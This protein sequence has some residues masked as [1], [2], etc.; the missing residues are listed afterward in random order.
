MHVLL[1]L[2][3]VA[4]AVLAASVTLNILRRVAGWEQRRDL[5]LLVLAAPV[6]GLGLSVAGLH[7]F[8][9]RVCFLSAPPW[10]RTLGA[11]FPLAMA[12]IALGGLGLGLLRL[13]LMS[14]TITRRSVPA[15]PDLQGLTESLARGLQIRVPRVLLCDYDRPL[16]LSCGLFRPTIL[17]SSW[18]IERL[19]Q[20]ELESV[21]A[22]ELGHV[23]RRDYPV[24]WL[25][26]VLRD[27]FFYLPPTWVAYR[28]LKR[29]GELACDD[30]AVHATRRPL[31]L[32]SALG[33]VWKQTLTWP[34]LSVA[35]SLAASSHA[36]ETRIGRLLTAP[37]TGPRRPRAFAAAF[38]SGAAILVGLLAAEALNAMI[39]FTPMGCGP[40]GVWGRL[41]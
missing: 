21:L 29:E 23:V 7:H 36:M 17:V 34:A 5:Q 37:A 28:Q 15:P 4:L 12:A 3:S 20:G 14:W 6:V 39:L 41:F 9:D 2:S 18:M 26:T 25:A 11:G 35:R 16:A 22:H 30:L 10:D 24:I 13:A 40:A 31:A 38:G 33:K 1:G 19:D 27:A 8:T 32:A